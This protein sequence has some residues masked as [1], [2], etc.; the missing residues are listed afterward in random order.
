VGFFN[1]NELEFS[2][3]NADALK[4]RG[5]RVKNDISSGVAGSE[6]LALD[7]IK[8]ADVDIPLHYCSASYKD[9]VQLR[10]RITRRAIN[11]AR[12]GDIVTDDGLLVKGV[13]ECRNMKKTMTEL[14]TRYGV[15]KGLVYIDREK[16]RLEVAPWVLKR[17][18]PK[19][20][21]P[22]FIVEE[23]PTADRLEVEKMRIN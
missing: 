9:G 18:A 23:Y 12:Q 22:C 14:L 17:I 20:P 1:L 2:E 6:K 5:Y 4:S 21:D 7:I 11:I 13:I 10:N 16:N 3:T 19:L 15:R 8:N